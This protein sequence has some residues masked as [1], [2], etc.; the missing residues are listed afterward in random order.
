M[1][2]V[3]LVLAL[4]AG[5]TRVTEATHFA[6]RLRRAVAAGVAAARPRGVGRPSATY[7]IPIEGR[8]EW[9]AAARRPA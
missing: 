5:N 8:D 7:T 3:E 9:M 4:L 1:S 6:A 2:D